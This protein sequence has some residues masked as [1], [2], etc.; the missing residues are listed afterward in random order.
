[1]N[2]SAPPVRKPWQLRLYDAYLS[3]GQA[4]VSSNTPQEAFATRRAYLTEFIA[5]HFPQDR[6]ARILDIACGHGK[7]LY[8][9]SA[10]GYIH[11]EGVDVSQEQVDAAHRLGIPN[12]VCG[13]AFDHVAGLPDE[14]LDVAILFDI[15][16]HLEKQDLFDLIDEV[17]RTLRPGGVCLVH[18]PNGEGIF[19]MRVL[20]G[21]LTHR[22]AFTQKSF[23]QLFSTLGFT[24]I[25]CFED[26][27][28]VHG[29]TSLVR[30]ILWELGT[31]PFRL[32][33]KAETGDIRPILSQNL[34]GR[35]VKATQGR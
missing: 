30:R 2:T 15:L 33:I 13:P 24:R 26:R 22:Q 8:F 16:E 31:A 32:L 19:A 35:A 23:A 27:P 5:K 28:V 4:S 29:L 11:A 21:D 17:H 10:A 18:V 12:V 25:E 34:V 3:S 6:E 7:M 20:F 1:M 14:S 9:L